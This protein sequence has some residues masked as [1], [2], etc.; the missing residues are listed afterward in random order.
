MP[1]LV[2]NQPRETGQ[3]IRT[4]LNNSFG[5]LGI[6]HA[7]LGDLNQ[8]SDYA[9]RALER[10][11][12]QLFFQ[13]MWLASVQTRV[14]LLCGNL[15]A[16]ETAFRDGRVS[17]SVE[18]YGRLFPPGAPDLY[19]AAAE[20]ALARK[21]YAQV[22]ELIDSLLERLR[23]ARTRVAI[24]EALYLKAQALRGQQQV[25]Q[26]R[27]TLQEARAEA[28]AIGV[29]RKLWQILALLG[30]IEAAAG[31]KAEAQAARTQARDVVDY[32][33]AHVPADLRAK[34]LNLP[35]VNAVMKPGS[36]E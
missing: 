36:S 11:S 16:A 25:D 6:I 18:N 23:Y 4:I 7:D 33:A 21:E 15:S 9:R 26:A 31:N 24:P 3:K 5:M 12:S 27:T 10:P 22:I 28:Q 19:F 8:A 35:E 20:L 29:R 1:G 14:E 34:F 32:I 2:A 30:E 13:R 17:A